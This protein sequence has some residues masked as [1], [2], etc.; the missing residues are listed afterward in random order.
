ML[1]DIVN[2]GGGLEDM[3]QAYEEYIDKDLLEAMYQRIETTAKYGE[4]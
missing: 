1:I 2:S 3:I 4:V